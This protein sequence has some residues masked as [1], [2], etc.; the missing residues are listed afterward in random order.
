MRKIFV[1]TGLS[2]FALTKSLAQ[3]NVNT[4][5]VGDAF[6]DLTRGAVTH[7][8][9]EFH[10]R[11]ATVGSAYMFK[12]W[13][14]GNVKNQNDTVINNPSLL[15]NYDK[16]KGSLMVTQDQA[17]YI[18][19][20]KGTYKSFN[21]V[22]ADGIEHIFVAIPAISNALF[23]EEIAKTEKYSIYKLTKT[24]FKRADYRTDGL[25]ETGNN[26]D[27][28]VDEYEYYVVNNKDKSGQAIKISAKRKSVKDAFGT[29]AAKVDAYVSQ[30][31]DDLNDNY[32]KL[33]ATYLNQ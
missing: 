1:I 10:P 2:L 19:L 27:E 6:Q 5:V 28:Y 23:P 24:K 31:K 15:Y 29:D 32:F 12:A 20:S 22:D 25:T 18:E 13:V 11:D 17:N 16:T 30:H 4:Q 33:L 26:Y 3:T 8:A 7:S 9:A 14:K 21:L